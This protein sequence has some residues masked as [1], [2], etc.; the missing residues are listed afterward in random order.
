MA[1]PKANRKTAEKSTV[2]CVGKPGASNRR[3]PLLQLRQSIRTAKNAT[4]T[5]WTCVGKNTPKA[6]TIPNNTPGE[7]ANPPIQVTKTLDDKNPLTIL[8]V[9]EPA[10]KLFSR[11]ISNREKIAQ[12]ALR[13]PDAQCE[14]TAKKT[15]WLYGFDAAWHLS[16]TNP[17]PPD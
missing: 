16:P 2:I 8:L 12:H 10:M 5:I 4:P 6:K 15:L 9:S 14:P 13:K 17:G 3:A 7:F 11:A 1:A